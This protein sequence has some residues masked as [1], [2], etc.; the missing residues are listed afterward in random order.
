MEAKKYFEGNRG[1]FQALA[2]MVGVQQKSWT[3]LNC[4]HDL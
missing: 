2:Y 4:G 1:A 3:K